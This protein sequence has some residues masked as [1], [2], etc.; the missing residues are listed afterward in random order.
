MRRRRGARTMTAAV[1]RRSRRA[2]MTRRRMVSEGGRGRRRRRMVSE[3]G[4]GRRRRRRR[5]RRSRR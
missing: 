5:R 4:R 1:W 3:R 2:R